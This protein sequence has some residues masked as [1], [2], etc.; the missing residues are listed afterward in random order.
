MGGRPGPVLAPLDRAARPGRR[1][2]RRA[3]DRGRRPARSRCATRPRSTCTSWP[4]PR[5]TP[6]PAAASSSPTTTTSRPTATSSQG[7]A[8]Q[9]GSELR[10]IRTDL[11][12]GLGR[13]RAARAPWTSAPRWSASRTW[14]T[15]A[16]RWPTWRRSPAI[17]HEAGRA[18][19]VGPVPL[20]RRG[21]GGAGRLRRRPGRRLHLQVPERR[22]RRARVPLRAPRACSRAAPAGLGLVRPAGPVRDGPGLRPGAGHRPVPDRDAADHRH[23]RGR[24]RA[25]GCSARPGSTGCAP[26]RVAL[27]GYLIGL[28]DEWLAPHRRHGR[29]AAA[30]P[31]GAARTSPSRHPEA[32][33]ISQALIRR[34]VIGDYRTPGPAPARPRPA[35]HQ[36]HRRLG[37]AGHPAAD[38]GRPDLPGR[39]GG[40]FRQSPDGICHCPGEA[41][42]RPRRHH[43]GSSAAVRRDHRASF[44]HELPPW[45]GAPTI[46]PTT[47]ATAGDG[48]SA[49]RAGP[50][51]DPSSTPTRWWR[52]ACW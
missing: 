16:A 24:R 45:R 12:Q 19:A 26:R 42:R 4:A 52:A 31:S 36:V 49:G 5:W 9:R 11:D 38:H 17:V 51:Y 47:C 40:A 43:S 21:P 32:W 7:I 30:R 14:P 34:G 37:R 41:A 10:M 46:P 50:R 39:P 20:G 44:V 33:R 35:L 6:G 8:A 2:A 1:P 25:P 22:A 48:T 29:L 3:P 28:A 15:A 27:T 13:G 23:G 18:R